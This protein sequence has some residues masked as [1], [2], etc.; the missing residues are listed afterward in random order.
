MLSAVSCTPV[1]NFSAMRLFSISRGVAITNEVLDRVND[2]RRND[3]LL[4]LA[5]AGENERDVRR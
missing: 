2:D 1:P 3:R 5:V 4:I